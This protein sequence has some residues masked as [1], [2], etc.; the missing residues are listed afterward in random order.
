MAD[1]HVIFPKGKEAIVKNDGEFM[2]SGE[3][4]TWCFYTDDPE[5]QQVEIEFEG[6][7]KACFFPGGSYG[8]YSYKKGVS[9][10]RAEIYGYV[11]DYPGENAPVIAKYTVRGLG[12][13]GTPVDEMLTVVD[14]VIITP[15]P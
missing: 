15:K 10:G 4:V 5:V 7:E 12:S 8:P 1:I 11:P 2:F 14:P 3:R 9:K 6:N 13:D